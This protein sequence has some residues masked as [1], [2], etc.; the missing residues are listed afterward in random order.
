[1]SVVAGKGVGYGLALVPRRW[2]RAAVWLFIAGAAAAAIGGNVLTSGPGPGGAV[3]FLIAVLPGILTY[4]AW[5]TMLASALVSLVPLYFV[6]GGMTA[7]RATHAPSV[8]LDTLIPVEPAW[9]LVYGSLYVFVVLLPFLVVRQRDL[10]RRALLAYLTVVIVSYAGFLLYPVAGPR[11]AQV[12]GEGFLPWT[13]RLA[14][15]LDI[16]YGCFPSLHV[17]YSFVSALAC[18]RVHRRVGIAAACWASLIGVST[19]FTKQH[20]AVDVLAGALLA[21]LAYICF[22]R[23]YPRERVPEEDRRLA[24]RRAAAVGGL[25]ALAIA[26]FWILYK[27]GTVVV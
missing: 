3:V 21:W 1:M 4:L 17:A 13:L 20:Y 18:Y 8:F 6:I 9:M 27:T 23:G 5:R 14:Y 24:P 7:G 22:L 11:P 25:Y 19:L 10:G 16:P 2:R 12:P 26:G 15:A